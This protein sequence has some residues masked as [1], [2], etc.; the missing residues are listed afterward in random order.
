MLGITVLES[1]DLKKKKKVQESR[2]PLLGMQ[3]NPLNASVVK[4]LEFSQEIAC[5]EPFL[6]S[7]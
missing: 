5:W 4:Y 6:S 1:T 3:E 2:A 7:L